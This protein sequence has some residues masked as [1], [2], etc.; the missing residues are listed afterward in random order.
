MVQSV[1]P[2]QY[3][4]L[5]SLEIQRSLLRSGRLGTVIAGPPIPVTGQS[6]FDA[7]LFHRQFRQ[8]RPVQMARW[9][10]GHLEDSGCSGRLADSGCSGRL[11]DS[12]CSGRL[13]DL[14][15]SDHLADLGSSARLGYLGLDFLELDPSDPW[16]CWAYWDCSLVHSAHWDCL[17]DY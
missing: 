14:G 16:A 6:E 4:S 15:C 9:V 10:L 5:A 17:A 3:F 13:A 11:A 1:F 2:F 7:T 12:G 8:Y